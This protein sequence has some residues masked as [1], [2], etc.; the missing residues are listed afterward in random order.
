MISI[1]SAGAGHENDRQHTSATRLGID[2]SPQAVAPR[3]FDALR[4]PG[5]LIAT[6]QSVLDG[7]TQF[8]ELEIPQLILVLYQ[9]QGFA[10][11]FTGR[12]GSPGRHL[13]FHHRFQ[14]GREV[15]I[16]RHGWLI[17]L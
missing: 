7:A 12:G 16:R 2:I 1:T 13:P 14:L 8:L 9:S 17:G 3:G 5:R 15:D 6:V 4:V 10:H 11:H